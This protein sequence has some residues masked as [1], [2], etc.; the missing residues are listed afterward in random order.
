MHHEAFWIASSNFG[1]AL[2][3]YLLTKLTL[4][5]VIYCADIRRYAHFIILGSI[6]NWATKFSIVWGAGLA[7]KNDKVDPEAKLVAV[8]GP[9]SANIARMCGNPVLGDPALLLPRFYTPKIRDRYKVG[10]IPHYT[11]QFY[12]AQ[13]KHKL[14]PD[15]KFINILGNIEKV[16]DEICSCNVI[17]SSSLHGLIVSDAYGI[18]NL[19]VKMDNGILGDGMKYDDYFLSVGITP[20]QPVDIQNFYYKTLDGVAVEVP[21]HGFKYDSEPLLKCCPITEN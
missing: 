14:H 15:I 20:Y 6:L 13:N 17:L 5:K 9:L 1:D 19:Y 3:Y 16:I 18:K 12:Y 21:T 8:R 2:N 11:D 4:R 7:N 10:I